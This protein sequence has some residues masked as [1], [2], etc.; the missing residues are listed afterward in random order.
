MV[1]EICTLI[2][3]ILMFYGSG[4]LGNCALVFGGF[5]TFG[6]C[7]A[8]ASVVAYPKIYVNLESYSS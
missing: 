7:S 8:F 4:T 5:D 2:N 3:C 6:S 1:V